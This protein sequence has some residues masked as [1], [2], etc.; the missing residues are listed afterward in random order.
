MEKENKNGVMF[1]LGRRIGQ[2]DVH[3][4]MELKAELEKAEAI[5][6]LVQKKGYKIIPGVKTIKDL[7]DY[8][9]VGRSKIYKM[10]K[11]IATLKK[12]LEAHKER[13]NK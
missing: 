12:K 13:M 1:N 11:W 5:Q 6:T 9:N 4:L 3:R 10:D 8:F 7:G 2:M